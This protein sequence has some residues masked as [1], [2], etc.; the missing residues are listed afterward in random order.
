MSTHR[1]FRFNVES[2]EAR[3][4]PSL[5]V[6]DLTTRGAVATAPSGAIVQQA[7]PTLHGHHHGHDGQRTFLRLHD[8][9]VERGYNSGSRSHQFDEEC[10]TRALRLD[11]VP[12]VYVDG[13]AYREFLLNVN[14]ERWSPNIS[15]DELRIYLGDSGNLSGYDARTK[16]LAG[17]TAAFDLDAGGNVSVKVNGRLNRDNGSV[18]MVLLIPDSAFAASGEFVYLY[19]KFGGLCGPVRTAGP[20]NGRSAAT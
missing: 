3:L 1:S 8:K 20:R 12:V 11:R 17:M 5:T 15:L 18:D 2:L 13:V 9:G 16:E 19:S 10:G 14:Q 6:L 4:V 7:S